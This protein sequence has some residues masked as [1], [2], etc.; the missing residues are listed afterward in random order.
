M[1]LIN[2]ASFLSFRADFGTELALLSN[3]G[4]AAVHDVGATNQQL[5]MEEMIIAAGY[6][7]IWEYTE[8][9]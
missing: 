1:G 3:H 2:R 8:M 4:V 6:G 7:N 5:G 9:W